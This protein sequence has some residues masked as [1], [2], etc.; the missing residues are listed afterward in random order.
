MT[1]GVMAQG[2]ITYDLIKPKAYE[3]RKLASE[4][5]PDKKINPVKRLKENIVSHYN[6]HFNANLKLSK[7]IS[8]AKQTY[9]DTFTSPDS[10]FQL[11]P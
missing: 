6:F 4:L 9:K 7:V 8:S 2:N 1:M 5:T 11:Q 3:N 10:I